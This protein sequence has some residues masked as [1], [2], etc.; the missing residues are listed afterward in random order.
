[1]AFG[2]CYAQCVLR[3]RIKENLLVRDHSTLALVI[4]PDKIT[5]HEIAISRFLVDEMELEKPTL[6]RWYH[7]ETARF[8]C[9]ITCPGYAKSAQKPTHLCLPLTYLFPALS[10]KKPSL[11]NL[12]E[13]QKVITCARKDSGCETSWCNKCNTKLPK[14]AL[15]KCDDPAFTALIKER[16]WARCPSASMCILSMS[17]LKTRRGL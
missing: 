6:D 17:L 4:S 8:V 10:C 9:E 3:I 16:H 15:H 7:F 13:T 14:D 11:I 1:M 5:P 12:E 2:Q